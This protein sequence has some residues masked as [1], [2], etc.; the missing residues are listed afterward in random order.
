MH[1]DPPDGAIIRWRGNE[2][3]ATR[4]TIDVVA[5]EQANLA[6]WRKDRKRDGKP[7]TGIALS[8][9]G[10]RSATF[11]LGALRALA[12]RDLLRHF[13]YMSTV[14]GGGYI[15][16][17]LQWWWHQPNVGEEG[18]LGTGK[19]DF[20]FGTSKPGPASTE[21]DDHYKQKR[22]GCLRNHG[23]YLA[24]GGAYGPGIGALLRSILLN[25]I[26]WIPLI[27][28]AFYLLA[29]IDLLHIKSL[30]S[31]HT[32][33]IYDNTSRLQPASAPFIY[34]ALVFVVT[35]MV[36]FFII[37]CTAYSFQTIMSEEG[38]EERWK[39]HD[40]LLLTLI[41]IGLFCIVW[42][43]FLLNDEDFKN[44]SILGVKPSIWMPPAA[45]TALFI[46]A[47]LL[48]KVTVLEFLRKRWFKFPEGVGE[49]YSF[50][51]LADYYFGRW[52][53]WFLIFLIIALIPIFAELAS[54][55]SPQEGFWGFVLGLGAISGGVSA[56][57]WGYYQAFQR[58][59]PNIST[60][61]LL[62]LGGALFL[63]GLVILGYYFGMHLSLKSNEP[64]LFDRVASYLPLPQTKA[65][66]IM[67]LSIVVASIFSALFVNINQI[68][69]NRL[70]RDR[71]MEAYMPNKCNDTE[72]INTNTSPADSLYLHD[73]WKWQPLCIRL[74]DQRM[75]ALGVTEDN[76][77]EA[78]AGENLTPAQGHPITVNSPQTPFSDPKRLGELEVLSPRGA[79][80]QLAEIANIEP[81]HSPPGPYPLINTNVV[82]VN[83]KKDS[84]YQL[85][86][87]DNYV[88]SPFFCGS[89]A[90]DW[91]E[92]KTNFA[93]VSLPTAMAAS[94]AA[95]NPFT[96][97][98]GTGATRTWLVSVVLALLNLRL[99]FWIWNP[100]RAKLLKWWPRVP[101]HILPG[102]CY[103]VFRKGH[104]HKSW[105][106][107]LTDGGHF[108][109]LG[110]YELVRRKCRV[111]LVLDGE[112]DKETSYAALVSVQRRI[113]DDFKAEIVFDRDQSPELLVEDKEMDYPSG[114]LRAEQ[115]YF[116]ATIIY[117]D[118]S[119]GTIIYVKA[120]MIKELSFEVKAYKGAHP[121]FPHES[122][123][124]QFFDPEQFDAH[125]ELGYQACACGYG[126]IEEALADNIQYSLDFY[127]QTAQR[128]SS[129]C[130]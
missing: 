125:C 51:H 62:L 95:I 8:G 73:F 83:D 29:S 28:L 66:K 11:C 80:V 33:G 60:R 19:K 44:W 128:V 1:R 9:G 99:G 43:T 92:T 55:A 32:L 50:R 35:L 37:A 34:I 36:L 79:S 69:L 74:D 88:L 105:Y 116:V 23:N 49:A 89:K 100:S 109:N 3:G 10:I 121:D 115:T 106:L 39:L 67:V 31:T 53:K 68:S 46:S 90:T 111:I 124:D 103:G 65:F 42:V 127:S 48:W 24:P 7:W 118:K 57:L 63:I 12:S 77:R 30:L 22:L 40:K 54:R 122:T 108:D 70:Y 16:C 5:K 2:M 104:T 78:L 14:S 61:I 93:H 84:K 97:Y 102:F 71:L 98:L 130:S 96:G 85:R 18:I 120:R 75:K 47:C 76:V 72:I 6:S 56:S 4:E 17:S 129:D 25:L 117:D 52:F 91:A 26:V 38:K 110:I 59:A 87:G 13:D 45:L 64:V 27:G 58:Y 82:L 20:P 126:A 94:G 119:R 113:K 112:M 123:T 21:R 114:A 101:N 86:G 41:V 15:G 107:E 81:P